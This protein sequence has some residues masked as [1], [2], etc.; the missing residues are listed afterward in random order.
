MKD[1]TTIQE[2]A[3]NR[4]STLFLRAAVVALGIIAL[5]L[6][7]LLLPEIYY[8]FENEFPS[9]GY[10]AYPI[11]AILGAALAP[12]FV[13]LYQTMKLLKYIDTNQAFS[14][15]SV[16]ALRKIK[17]SG[18]VF[19]GLF[20]ALLPFVYMVAE[21]DDAPGLIILGMVFAG[22]PMV[23]AVFAALL[24]KLLENAIAMKNEN[25]LTV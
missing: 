12:Y 25:D 17:Y 9:I 20:I 5:G 19:S 7:F 2:T 18:L 8:N 10:L 1:T 22:A 24:E 16:S 21:V 3:M 13:A 15:L 23:I 14:M 11:V 4:V 6:S